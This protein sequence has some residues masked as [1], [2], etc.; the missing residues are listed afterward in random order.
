MCFLHALD[1]NSN[2]RQSASARGK[3]CMFFRMASLNE[4]DF[5]MLFYRLP[6]CTSRIFSSWCVSS[7]GLKPVMRSERGEKPHLRGHFSAN[8]A[9][10]RSFGGIIWV[11]FGAQIVEYDI[12]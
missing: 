12:A 9:D 2:I 4:R 6:I 11:D 8:S 7:P 3:Q 1:V 10:V 5:D